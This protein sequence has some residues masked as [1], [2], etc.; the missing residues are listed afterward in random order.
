MPDTMLRS[1]LRFLTH[2]G[3]G[4]K[5]KHKDVHD[6]G[7]QRS[8]GERGFGVLKAEEPTSYWGNRAASWKKWP[9]SWILEQKVT[10]GVQ[11]QGD[12]GK[13]RD[14]VWRTLGI[15][16]KLA[17]KLSKGNWEKKAPGRQT[18]DVAEDLNVRL[19]QKLAT[20]TPSRS[21]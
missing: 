16:V 13:E 2:K 17:G 3:E 21:Q 15:S 6:N 9:L 14:C 5:H 7:H 1:D 11:I 4:N 10:G 20:L 19:G 12:R 18:T 8:V